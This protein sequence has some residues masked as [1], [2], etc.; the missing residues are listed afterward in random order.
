MQINSTSKSPRMQLFLLCIAILSLASLSNA[1]HFYVDSNHE[2][3][4]LEE[5]S[6]DTV[7]L[8]VYR[9]EDYSEAAKAYMENTDLAVTV[10]VTDTATSN[11]LVKTKTASSGRFS[12]TASHSGEYQVC[13]RYDAGSWWTSKSVRIYLDTVIGEGATKSYDA[14]NKLKGV[15]QQVE[16][17]VDEVTNIRRENEYQREREVQFRDLS[18]LVNARIVHWTIVQICILAVTCVWQLR[19]LKSFFTSKKLV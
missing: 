14:A 17:L 7:F 19:H 4:F 10:T 3:C 18:E 5:L 1:F 9:T 2:K 16:T 11:V 12:F 13:M 15:K 6:Q 8:G